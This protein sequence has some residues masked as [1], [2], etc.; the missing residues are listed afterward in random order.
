MHVR[1]WQCLP[2]PPG[3]YVLGRT[4]HT[5]VSFALATKSGQF[6]APVMRA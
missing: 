3:A 4:D 6:A 2:H 5:G 1:G